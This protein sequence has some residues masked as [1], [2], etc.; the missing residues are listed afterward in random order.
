[1][2]RDRP[3]LGVMLMLGFCI[4]AP[5]ADATKKSLANDI[6]LLELLFSRYLIQ[7]VVLAPIFIWAWHSF[8]QTRAVTLLIVLRA[9]LLAGVG[10]LMILSLRYLPLAD[11]IAIAFVEPFIL[12]LLGKVFMNEEVGP[13]R[14]WACA[15]GFVGTLLVIQPNF[16]EVG[17]LALLPLSVA[18]AFAIFMLVTR[19]LAKIVEPIPLQAMTAFWASVLVLPMMVILPNFTSFDAMVLP[20]PH[21]FWMMVVS[22]T[23]GAAALVLMTASLKFAPSATLAPMQYLELPFATL[24]GWWFFRDLP[25]GLASLG[26]VVTIAAGL[27]IIARERMNARAAPLP[28]P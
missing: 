15:V 10:A 19:R 9:V 17:F 3:Y 28:Q 23:A 7:A 11:T 2:T 16:A 12:L 1:M 21:E 26:I 5:V 24:M 22:G 14:L 13:H 18:L 20:K 25:D 4:L 6:P 27:Y 8:F